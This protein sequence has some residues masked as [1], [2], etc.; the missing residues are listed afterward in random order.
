M[1]V[2]IVSKE[3]GV[4]IEK[5]AEVQPEKIIKIWINPLVGMKSFQA[6]KLAHG[7]GIKG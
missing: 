4:E 2:F 3:G 1:D 7:L 6:R 5:I